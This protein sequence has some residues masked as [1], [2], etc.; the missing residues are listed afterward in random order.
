MFMYS[1]L[2]RSSSY[3]SYRSFVKLWDRLGLLTLARKYTL[4]RCNLHAMQK[5]RTPR[6]S[7]K[8]LKNLDEPTPIG[9]DFT[10]VE[11]AIERKII[12]TPLLELS[13]YFDAVGEVPPLADHRE[14]LGIDL[15]DVGNGD[16]A[17]EWGFDITVSGGVVRYGPWAD[18]QRAEL[19]KAFFPP[20]HHDGEVTPPLRPGDKR[21]WTA[22]R[23][24]VELR[25]NTILHIPFREASKARVFGPQY[26]SHYSWGF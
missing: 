1:T 7:K 3:L 22:M 26:Y 24:F 10:Q 25:D 9:A 23:V 14:N 16:V 21:L 13:Y 15:I 6:P 2:S 17:P 18:R 8:S 12:E 20:T 5:Q 11:Y 19:Q 4:D